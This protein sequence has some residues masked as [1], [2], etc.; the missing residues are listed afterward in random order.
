MASIEFAMRKK[1]DA[2]D[3][4]FIFYPS[5][6]VVSR[7][8]GGEYCDV[9]DVTAGISIHA[10]NCTHDNDDDPI[11]FDQWMTNLKQSYRGKATWKSDLGTEVFFRPADQI[12]G[13]EYFFRESGWFLEPIE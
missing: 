8:S 13:G 11:F 3:D 7:C 4:M 12:T 2:I 6:H 9:D 10:N 1:G 5:G